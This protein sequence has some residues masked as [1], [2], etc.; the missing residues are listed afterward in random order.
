MDEFK[1]FKLM[2]N[3]PFL[4]KGSLFDF[5]YQTA[6]VYGIEESGERMEYPLRD[7]LAGYLWLLKTEGS[8]YLKEVPS[9]S[10]AALR[11]CAKME[12]LRIANA[13]NGL[14]F[15]PFDDVSM[16]L[17]THGHHYKQGYFRIDAMP[18][19]AVIH[20]L[21]GGAI[22]IVDA[23]PSGKLLCSSFRNGVT[24]W[25]LVFNRAA[26]IYDL[27][28][29]EWQTIHHRAAAHSKK[30]SPLCQRIRRLIEVYGFKKPAIIGD[31]VL[32]EMHNNFE[33]DDKPAELGKILCV[34]VPT[35]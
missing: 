9:R 21:L 17:S 13:T 29:A 6:W 27:Q 35:K 12:I 30:H 28:V 32:L 22:K 1:R 8:R 25:C 4:R 5:E 7:G 11:R 14:A 10:L 2:I 31:N 23:S 26:H 3:L 16:F 24:T 33:L 18:Y 15:P 19:R 34:P 20:L